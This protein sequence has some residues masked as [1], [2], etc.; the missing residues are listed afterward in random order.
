MFCG[1]ITHVTRRLQAFGLGPYGLF[2]FTTRAS[3]SVANKM[4]STC[5]SLL[6]LSLYTITTVVPVYYAYVYYAVPDLY[7]VFRAQIF[8]P[9]SSLAKGIPPASQAILTGFMNMCIFAL[10]SV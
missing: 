10:F 5:F 7:A 2:S 8:P 6:N 1:L 3:P 9:I 4:F